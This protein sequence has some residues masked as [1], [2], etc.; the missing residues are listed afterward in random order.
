MV[1]KDEVMIHIEIYTSNHVQGLRKTMKMVSATN[2][3]RHHDTVCQ[4]ERSAAKCLQMFYQSNRYI[5]TTTNRY[6]RHSKASNEFHSVERFAVNPGSRTG[7]SLAHSVSKYTLTDI[8]FV[9]SEVTTAA[10]MESAVFWVLLPGGS[11]T[12]RRFEETYCHRLTGRKASQAS[13]KQYA[14]R[15]VP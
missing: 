12:A 10:T 15:K 13:N 6:N 1:W 8:N 2:P 7:Q 14:N 5:D 11:K 3:D 9:G 4:D